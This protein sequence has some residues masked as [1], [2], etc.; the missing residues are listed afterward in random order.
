M[1]QMAMINE[2]PLDPIQ[3][4]KRERNWKYKNGNKH[5]PGGGGGG[6]G[7]G[8]RWIALANKLT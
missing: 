7:G 6:W 5:L 8:V 2:I 4:I 1:A 3:N